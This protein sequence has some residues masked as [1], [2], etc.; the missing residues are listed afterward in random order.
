[1]P[2]NSVS[3]VPNAYYKENTRSIQ[4][5]Q[6]SRSLGVVYL[7]LNGEKTAAIMQPFTT[8]KYDYT[9]GRINILR[10]TSYTLP[11]LLQMLL[12]VLKSTNC[13]FNEGHLK[14]INENTRTWY[15]MHFMIERIWLWQSNFLSKCKLVTL[16]IHVL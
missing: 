15:L 14:R 7:P 4:W 9:A 5:N 1:M 10:R 11:A 16:G 8:V 6:S 12:L 3:I 13:I 2:L